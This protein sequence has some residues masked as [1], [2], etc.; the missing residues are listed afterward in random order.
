M[1]SR[2]LFLGLI[3]GCFSCLAVPALTQEPQDDVRGAFLTTRPK[4][5]DKSAKG[6]ETAKPNRR[7]PKTSSSKPGTSGSATLTTNVG[8]SD[9]HAKVTSQKLG[10]GLTLFTRDS[11]GLAVRVDPTRTFHRGDRV[12]VLLETNADGYLYIFNTTNGGKPVMIY[13]NRELDEGGNYLRSHIPLR[14]P[15]ARL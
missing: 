14:F 3:V 10:L 11:L 13:P 2:A 4:P 8:T 9:T 12:R 15:Q 7:R 1:K 6:N 5:V